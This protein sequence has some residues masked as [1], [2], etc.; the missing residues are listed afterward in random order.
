[1]S[2]LLKIIKGENAG[3]EIALAEG[4]VTFGSGESCDI[5]LDDATLPEKAFTLETIGDQVSLLK[6][7]EEAKAVELYTIFTAGEMEFAI[8]I[9][10]KRW[11]KLKREIG[12]VSADGSAVAGVGEGKGEDVGVEEPKL[13]EIKADEPKKK[14]RGCGCFTVIVLIVLA[15]IGGWYLAQR[16]NAEVK[17]IVDEAKEFSYDKIDKEAVKHYY[18]LAKDKSAE[19]YAIGK[20]KTS[21]WFDKLKTKMPWYVEEVDPSTLPPPRTLADVAKD[22]GLILTTD[23]GNSTLSG[24]FVKRIDKVAAMQDAYEVDSLV[25]LDFSD[26]ES[27]RSGVEDTLLTISEGKVKVVEAK[28]RAVKLVGKVATKAELV[29]I[30]TAICADVANV[31]SIDDSGVVV[32]ELKKIE[33][34]KKAVAKVEAEEKKVANVQPKEEK[35]KVEKKTVLSPNCPIS[36]IITS[37]YPCII[38]RDGSRAIEGAYVGEWLVVKIEANQV[39]FRKNGKEVTW[40]P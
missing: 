23:S 7:G 10:G 9:E 17:V 28:A 6:E 38:M 19:Y 15:F 22:H 16:Y 36:G 40:R 21:G 1:M 39:K 27:L 13:E 2:F 5:V 35:R 8:G 31:S 3:L 18:D 26:D 4:K 29:R 30:V 34:E 33:E 25:K 11:P 14:R 24:N 32:E 37:P 12:P 20:D